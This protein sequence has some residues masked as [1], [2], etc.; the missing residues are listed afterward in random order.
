[1]VLNFKIRKFPFK[2]LFYCIV[3]CLS[4]IVGVFIMLSEVWKS[5]YPLSA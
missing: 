1:M 2:E 3:K 5:V 4:H